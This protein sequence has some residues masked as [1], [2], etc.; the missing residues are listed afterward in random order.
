MHQKYFQ[1]HVTEIY[2]VK[3][4]IVPEI[5]KTIFELQNPLYNLRW[6]NKFRGENIKTFIMT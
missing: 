1:V 2:K 4:G 6:S 5:M 3:Y